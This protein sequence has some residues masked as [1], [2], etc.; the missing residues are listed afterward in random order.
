MHNLSHLYIEWYSAVPD[1]SE[2]I[3]E[4]VLQYL[5]CVHLLLRCC[6]WLEV[7]MWYKSV[8]NGA[9]IAEEQSDSQKSRCEVEIYQISL[10]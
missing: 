4:T 8:E 7:K 9:E 1:C 10:K 3:L 5:F 6:S 2:L